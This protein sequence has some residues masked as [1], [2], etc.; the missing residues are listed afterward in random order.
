MTQKHHE[1]EVDQ[2]IEH[3]EKPE[4]LENL[5][6]DGDIDSN[7]SLGDL[8]KKF[9]RTCFKIVSCNASNEQYRLFG[10]SATIFELLKALRPI[11]E[12][13]DD[14]VFKSARD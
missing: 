5:N 12:K 10:D 7:H 9:L 3:E 13:I 4:R 11:F 8:R 14:S 1:F 2:F 6:A